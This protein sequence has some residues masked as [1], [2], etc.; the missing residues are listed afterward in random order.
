M[1][2]AMASHLARHRHEVKVWNR[3][4]SKAQP[5]VDNG[6]SLA[7]DLAEVGQ[8]DIIFVC[9]N[10]SEDVEAVVAGLNPKPGSLIVDHSTISPSVSEKLHHWLKAKGVGYMDAPITGGSM[11]A[12]KGTLTIFC[13]GEQEHFQLANPYMRAYAKRAE[14]VGGPGK[15]QM[16]KLAN[17]IAVGGALMGLC[18]TLAF[19]KKAGLDQRQA[20]EMIGSGAGGSWAF[21]NY[22]PKILNEDWTPGFSIENQTKDFNYTEAVAK[23]LGA[24]VPA[25]ELAN[26]LLKKMLDN[27]EGGLTTVALFKLL[28]E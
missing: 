26:Q 24:N 22:G 16:M 25:T 21:E 18:E 23:E 2:G 10:R 11:G 20:L 19:C 12:Q 3:T 5:V 6:A 13:G 1:G 27:G 28:S 9:V 8:C 4:P 14:L 7:A 15:G 17:Q